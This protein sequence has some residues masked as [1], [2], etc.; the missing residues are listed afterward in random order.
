MSI[1]HQLY[2]G[3][4]IPPQNHNIKRFME[5]V[6]P[7]HFMEEKV[8]SIN[9]YPLHAVALGAPSIGRTMKSTACSGR[10]VRLPRNW[11]ELGQQ[12]TQGEPLLSSIATKS[13]NCSGIKMRMQQKDTER[14]GWNWS[15]RAKNICVLCMVR[16][17]KWPEFIGFFHR[18]TVPSVET[19]GQDIWG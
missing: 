7:C 10:Q 16:R 5:G 14:G 18:W 13:E 9:W 15:F 17:S 11:S 6:D 2:H 8:T 12:E 1:N 19:N 4:A 3:R